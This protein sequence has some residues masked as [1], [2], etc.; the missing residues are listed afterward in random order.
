[1]AVTLSLDSDYNDGKAIDVFIVSAVVLLLH[2]IRR[3]S[4]RHTAMLFPPLSLDDRRKPL[5]S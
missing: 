1:M 5:L 2:P 4:G 3:L